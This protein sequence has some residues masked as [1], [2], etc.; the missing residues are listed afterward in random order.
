[1][2]RYFAQLDPDNIVLRV[3]VCNDPDWPAQRLGGT[4]VET[5]DPYTAP[6]TVAYCGPGHGYD[7]DWPVK[8]ASQWVQP[9]PIQNPE[10]DQEPWT[11]YHTGAVVFHNSHLWVSTLN[12]NVWEPGVSGWRR[13]PTTPGEPPP[14][15]QPTGEH[16][17]WKLD[18]HA[19]HNGTV[20]VVTQTDANGNNVWEPGVFGWT[21]IDP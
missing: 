19:T 8:F 4:W 7:A 14:W 6:G 5:S 11:W 9:V 17:A 2:S 18:E 21:Q 13:T 3:I 16:D 10:E 20:W 1:M 15:T 12:E